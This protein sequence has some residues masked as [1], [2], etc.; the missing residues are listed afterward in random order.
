MSG[1]PAV[2]SI[3]EPDFHNAD[4]ALRCSHCRATKPATE[5]FNNKSHKSGYSNRCKPCQM[6]ATQLWRSKNKERD[7]ENARRRYVENNVRH[8]ALQKMWRESNK[9]VIA[10]KA[11][12]YSAK[13]AQ[14]I[15]KRSID[16]D[17]AH[18]DSYKE[19]KKR[20]QA[21]NRDKVNA[22][23]SARRAKRLM[24]SPSWANAFFIAEAFH[25]AKLREKVTGFKW[26]VDHVVPLRSKIVCGLHVECNLQVIPAS[27][28]MAKGNRF[29][30]DMP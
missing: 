18:P 10:A 26:N 15:K 9:N 22:A 11:R 28:N 24:A 4:I 30:P 17:I 16:W 27:K 8:K 5:F 12:V 21:R 3:G 6:E 7:Q 25:L 29:W 23:T 14:A 1:S 20:Y 2:S 19:R 13:N